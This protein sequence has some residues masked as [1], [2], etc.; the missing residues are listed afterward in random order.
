MSTE[1]TREQ[2]REM[3]RLNAS[4]PLL[5]EEIP[6][7]DWPAFYKTASAGKYLARLMRS[8]H[9]LV[10]IYADE[11]PLVL[12]RLS[13][14]RTRIDGDTWQE[15]IL[16]QDLMGLKSECGYAFFDAVEVFPSVLDIVNVANMRHLWV[17]R[18]KLPFAWRR[19]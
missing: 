7:A 12:A 8:R 4:I 13:V 14:N 5:L 16:W 17:M 10:Q 1:S 19:P 15:G 11:H 18:D 2:R 6:S 9:W 3:K